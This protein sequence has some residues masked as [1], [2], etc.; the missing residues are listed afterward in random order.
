MGRGQSIPNT[1]YTD[2]FADIEHILQL[3]P[4]MGAQFLNSLSPAQ[5]QEYEKIL[6]ENREKD[7]YFNFT[8]QSSI[9]LKDMSDEIKNKFD[10]LKAD[11][12]TF[13]EDVKKVKT[14]LRDYIYNNS[15][16][17]QLFE[18]NQKIDEVNGKLSEIRR[19][20]PIF[21]GLAGQISNFCDN[22]RKARKGSTGE[23]DV[24]LY[25]QIKKDIENNRPFLTNG[26]YYTLVNRL[27]REYATYKSQKAIAK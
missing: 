5:R 20:F 15:S 23:G 19:S 17:F 21:Q 11:S 2:Y 26:A 27:E 13:C 10:N 1:A 24:K 16:Y 4:N 8:V 12:P 6:K 9:T 14:D 22:A 18:V 3:K 7:P 25:E